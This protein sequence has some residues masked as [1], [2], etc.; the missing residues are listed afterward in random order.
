MRFIEAFSYML[1]NF[2]SISS[3]VEG[4]GGR[5]LFLKILILC[6]QDNLLWGVF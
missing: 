4:F 1:R 2:T 3:Q 6:V 5:A